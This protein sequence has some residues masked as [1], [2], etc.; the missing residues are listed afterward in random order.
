LSVA[1]PAA[2][3]QST[4][5]LLGCLGGAVLSVCIGIVFP[6]EKDNPFSVFL[7]LAVSVVVLALVA[8]GVGVLRLP[9]PAVLACLAGASVLFIF[10]AVQGIRTSESRRRNAQGI[11]G[12]EFRR[13]SS[14]SDSGDRSGD[15]ALSDVLDG[16]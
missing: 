8:I 10:Y 1:D 2:V 9:E 16:R 15:T 6:A 14:R 12:R 13:R 5:P 11:V 7:G 3:A 4:M